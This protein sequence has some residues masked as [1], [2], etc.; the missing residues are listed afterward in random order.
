M[1]LDYGTIFLYCLYACIQMYLLMATGFFAFKRKMFSSKSIAMVSEILFVFLIPFYGLVE[2]TRIGTLEILNL[3]WILIVNFVINLVVSYLLSLVCHYT[4]K[5]DER[6]RESFNLVAAIPAMGALPLVIGKAFCFPGG[7]IEGDAYCD[8]LIGLMM[9]CYFVVCIAVFLVGFL[10]I[11]SDKSRN[12]SIQEKMIYLWHILVEKFFKKDDTILYLFNKYLKDKKKALILFEKFQ[13]EHGDDMKG[14]TYD[15]IEDHRHHH[16]KHHP[17]EVHKNTEQQPI[18]EGDIV[19][20]D[21]KG[22]ENENNNPAGTA[23]NHND[24]YFDDQSSISENSNENELNDIFPDNIGNKQKA[25]T[26]VNQNP[27]FSDQ[28]VILFERKESFYPG[29]DIRKKFEREIKKEKRDVYFNKSGKHFK[30][31]IGIEVPIE[32]EH[33]VARQRANTFHTKHKGFLL[34][35]SQKFQKENL[36]LSNRED[37]EK[38]PLEK[39]IDVEQTNKNEI[40][41]SDKQNSPINNDNNNNNPNNVSPNE[42]KEEDH[43]E[44]NKKEES[45]KTNSYIIKNYYQSAF[46]M[47]EEDPELFN[48]ELIKEYEDIKKE[49]LHKV[50][51]NPPKYPIVRS[52]KIDRNA[53]AL[54]NKEWE[55]FEPKLRLMSSSFKGIP[56]TGIEINLFL[57]KVISPPT[58]SVLFG[59]ILSISK[60]R[61]IIFDDKNHYWTNLVDGMYT[62]DKVMVPFLF[63]LIG[64]SSAST[65]GLSMNVPLTKVHIIIIFV[66]RFLV[67]PFLGILV[68]YIWKEA[69]GGIVKDSFAFRIILFFP[70]CLPSAPNMAV[71][72]NLTQY[73]FEEYGYLILIQNI[74]CVGT[75]TILYMIYFITVGL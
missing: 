36:N 25:Q 73:F 47:I 33:P 66:L 63:L 29:H 65:N 12:T 2:I 52:A 34:Q 42:N 40:K 20:E 9:L 44:R 53:V 60:I 68:I 18:A 6:I 71:I 38:V 5:L 64:L 75:L 7:P 48:L 59:L 69:Y 35:T 67:I 16:H 45:K 14:L 31:D 70:W 11:F 13:K 50:A 15:K 24:S 39:D 46:D 41:E 3:F 43:Q 61:E 10:L 1:D 27:Q 72:V 23:V 58:I 49:I 37:K 56:S 8:S 21:V 26:F 51:H 4:F 30:V 17:Y 19:I 55:T 74:A 54:I 57:K 32:H 22:F 62:I 28:F